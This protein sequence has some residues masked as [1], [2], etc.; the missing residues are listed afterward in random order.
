[1]ASSE[2][3]EAREDDRRREAI[4]SDSSRKRVDDAAWGSYRTGNEESLP[5][6]REVASRDDIDEAEQHSETSVP[7]PPDADDADISVSQAEFIGAEL[8]TA[9]GSAF[10]YADD[11][12]F[13]RASQD[14]P[15][16]PSEYVVDVH[17]DAKHV[18]LIDSDGY[19]R[20]LNADEFAEVL[21]RTS[22]NGEPVRLF[23]CNTGELSKGFAQELADQLGV[24]VT[25]PTAPVW[26]LRNERG[27][28]LSP[29][30]SE[31][32]PTTGGPKYPQTGDWIS[33]WP[34]ARS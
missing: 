23:S 16:F 25:A 10:Y 20:E 3:R 34:K 7:A 1:V 27:E 8:K 5:D 28:V 9:E 22:W 11:A 4:E 13:R 15:D 29:V 17:G 21:K 30:V 26:S 31:K 2:M 12:K 32:D 14:V 33:F 6:R 19:P 18:G 24:E